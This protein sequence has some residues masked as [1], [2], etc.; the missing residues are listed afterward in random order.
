M[1]AKEMGAVL[2]IGEAGSPHWAPGNPTKASAS[3]TG[4]LP[5]DSQKLNDNTPVTQRQES[6]NE[7]NI[8][9]TNNNDKVNKSQNYGRH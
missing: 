2:V 8:N 4:D 1:T 6:S 9:E 3:Q 7:I 5:K